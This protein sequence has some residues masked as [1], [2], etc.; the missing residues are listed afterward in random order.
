LIVSEVMAR[1][2][3]LLIF[4][5]VPGQE[6]WNAD[7]VVSAGAGVQV[8]LTSMVPVVAERLLHTPSYLDELRAGTRRAGKPQAACAVVDALLE[9]RKD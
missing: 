9:R 2:T 7:Y 1:H 4:D 8:R 3:P 5:P 6:E